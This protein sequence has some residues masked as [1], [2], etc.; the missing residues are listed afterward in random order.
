MIVFGLLSILDGFGS[1]LVY[2]TQPLWPDHTVRILRMLQG[3]IEIILGVTIGILLLH[4][5]VDRTW[6]PR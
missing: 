1:I 4:D 2:P 5:E 3:T 6:R